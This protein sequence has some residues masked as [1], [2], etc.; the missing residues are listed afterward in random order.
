MIKYRL[1][2]TV[3][4]YKDSQEAAQNFSES[5]V[6]QIPYNAYLESLKSIRRDENAQETT[7]AEDTPQ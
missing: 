2:I 6:K 1:K 4:F 3:E 7:Q 5:I